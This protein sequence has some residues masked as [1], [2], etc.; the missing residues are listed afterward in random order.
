MSKPCEPA[1][2]A[3]FF[4][5]EKIYG[6]FHAH[7]HDPDVEMEGLNFFEEKMLFIRLA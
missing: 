4:Y 3:G 7:L 6:L 2:S 5:K 1:V